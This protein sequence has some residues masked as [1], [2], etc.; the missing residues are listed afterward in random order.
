MHEWHRLR[1]ANVG[2]LWDMTHSYMRHDSF[3]CETRLIHVWDM[4]HPYH[5]REAKVGT[6]RACHCNT[7]L[8][9]TAAYHTICRKQMLARS[10][11]SLQHS[12]ATH[13]NTLQHTTAT[14]YNTLPFIVP[15]AGSGCWH[16]RAFRNIPLQCLVSLKTPRQSQKPTCMWVYICI[17]MCVNIYKH[18]HV[19]RDNVWWV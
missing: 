9:H 18:T 7:L 3:K 5:L 4:T 15:L 16:G 10:S 19:F 14:H 13:Y 1:K 8:Q 17:F 11:M 12:T 2:T 6:G